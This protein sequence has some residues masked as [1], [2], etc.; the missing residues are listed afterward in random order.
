[1]LL[2]WKVLE[3]TLV[4]LR[5]IVSKSTV[6]RLLQSSVCMLVETITFARLP[7]QMAGQSGGVWGSENKMDTGSK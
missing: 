5:E 7:K 1:M 2:K 3:K 4:L 6:D